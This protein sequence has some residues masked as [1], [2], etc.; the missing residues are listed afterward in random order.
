MKNAKQIWEETAKQLEKVYDAREAEN[1]TYLLMEDLFKIS[2]AAIL[3]EELVHVDE[4]GLSNALE[5]LLN[6]E[7]IQY[8]T[9]LADF[10]GRQFQIEKGAL[11]P[12]PETEELISLIK[13]NVRI[14]EPKM[15]DVGTGSGCIAITLS[16]E[17]GGI[18]F[19]TDISSKALN[20]AHDNA[21]KL[22][23]KVSFIEHDILQNDLT[24]SDL[25]VL[26]SNPPYIP[27]KERNQMSQNVTD[28]EPDLALFVPDDDPLLFYRRIATSGKNVLKSG[29]MLFF[30]IHENF[31]K[32]T[33]ELLE[34]LNYSVV[35]VHKDMQGKDRLVSAIN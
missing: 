1:I 10:Y 19:G 31:G 28:F 6:H 7:P 16:L 9:G 33:K 3:S 20:I 32:Q 35:K 27:Q 2:K 30:E 34:G 18:V 29:G 24:L 22:N 11:I 26:V 5:R 14:K 25:D 8:M 17:I 15:L 4:A 23:A 21:K 12:R 13:S